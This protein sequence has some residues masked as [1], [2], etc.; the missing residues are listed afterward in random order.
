MHLHNILEW[1][2]GM[3]VFFVLFWLLI[4]FGVVA[5]VRWFNAKT[6]FEMSSLELLKKRYSKGEISK[7]YFEKMKEEITRGND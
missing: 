3:Q 2:W 4:I 6:E 7:E 1:H 5:V